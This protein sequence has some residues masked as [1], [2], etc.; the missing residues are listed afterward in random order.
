VKLHGQKIYHIIATIQGRF[1][2]QMKLAQ[3]PKGLANQAGKNP[4][5]DLT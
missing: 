3:E 4:P 1:A 2:V 5:K